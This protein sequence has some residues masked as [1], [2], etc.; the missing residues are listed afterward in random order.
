VVRVFTVTVKYA[1]QPQ[2]EAGNYV[3]RD[4]AAHAAAVLAGA[5]DPNGQRPVG[6]GI[7]ESPSD[8]VR[9]ATTPAPA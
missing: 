6:V 1:G 9:P 8:G 7:H 4:V 3:S 2:R 5:E